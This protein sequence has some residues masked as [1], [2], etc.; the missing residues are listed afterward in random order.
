MELQFLGGASEIGSLGLVVRDQG[1]TLLFD[2]G[3]TPTDPPTYPRPAPTNIDLAF[4]SHAHLDHSGMTP[5]LSRLPK[6][7]L[8]ATPVTIA[9]ADLLTRDALKIA[10]LEGYLPPYTPQDIHSVAGR[11][12]A[13]DRR[14]TFRHKGI[15]VQFASA[16]HIPGASMMLYK[17]AQ[18][19]LFTGDLQTLPT[20]LVSGAEPLECDVLV[21]ESTYAGKEHPDRKETERRFRD[22]VAETVQR[23]G[24]VIVPAFAVGRAQEVLMSLAA[25]G[26]ET[27]LDG[28]ARKVN[29]I[30]L[31]APEYLADA[32]RFRRALEGVNVVESPGDRKR[33]L[34][35]ADVIVTTGGMLDGGPV[36]YYIGELYRDA[37]SSIFLTGYQV[38]GSNGR[39]LMDEG[40]LT[41]DETTIH[42]VCEIE[43]FDFSAHA[44]HSDLVRFIEESRAKT[45]ILMHGDHREALRDALPSSLDVRLPENGKPFT[46]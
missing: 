41:I 28:M 18:D 32:R 27:Y 3:M 16:G 1:R 4:L 34:R 37:N 20:H 17:G 22:K 7:R 21:I 36:L 38:E 10:R 46:I 31:S 33:A 23:G 26:F 44:G 43:K 30:Y 25:S 40:T 39:Q 15:E 8:V 6:A 29:S 9:V 14:A 12:T 5:V 13:V 19:V 2:Y 24:K 35:E 11:F 45:V 42:P